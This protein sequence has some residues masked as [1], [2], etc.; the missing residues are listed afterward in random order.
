MSNKKII[1]YFA[2][3]SNVW[4]PQMAER[5]V[6][7][8][9]RELAVL[10]GYKFDFTMRAKIYTG[11]S[12][13]NIEESRNDYVEGAVYDFTEEAFMQ[14]DQFEAYYDKHSVELTIRDEKLQRTD[15]KVT[16][17]VYIAKPEHVIYD[18]TPPPHY[19]ERIFLGGA[20]VFS[21]EY[22]A[23]IQKTVAE[24]EKRG[25]K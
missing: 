9:A 8:I 7:W 23:R 4:I 6:P 21:K 17:F 2:Y 20:D 18:K 5:N 1:K 15:K 12:V 3:G 10:D 22:L 13:A 11:H 24:A 16:A 19:V 14:V 25:K